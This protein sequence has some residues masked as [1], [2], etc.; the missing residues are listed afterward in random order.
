MTGQGR[1]DNT[2]ANQDVVRKPDTC[3]RLKSNVLTGT[4]VSSLVSL[5]LFNIL[6]LKQLLC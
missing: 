3:S 2:L 1:I 6:V 4:P 5:D